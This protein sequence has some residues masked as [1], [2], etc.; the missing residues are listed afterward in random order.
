[1][2]SASEV[3]SW[4]PAF[5]RPPMAADQAEP[6]IAAYLIRVESVEFPST[7]GNTAFGLFYPPHNPDYVPT[8][9]DKPPLLVRCHGGPTASAS[10]TLNLGIQYWTSRGI[11]KFGRFLQDRIT[12][13]S[14]IKRGDASRMIRRTSSEHD[15]IAF[16]PDRAKLGELRAASYASPELNIVR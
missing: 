7:G 5:T 15:P 9:G 10:S 6:R 13:G 3:T 2:P 4:K 14:Q 12:A 8:P 1:V 16:R 11:E